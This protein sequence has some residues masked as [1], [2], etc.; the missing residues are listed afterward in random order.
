MLT[1]H[2]QI[3]VN[4]M[5][6]VTATRNS[7]HRTA[8]D[9]GMRCAYC[10]EYESYRSSTSG[11]PAHYDAARHLSTCESLPKDQRDQLSTF[12]EEEFL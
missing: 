9:T 1:R 10:E 5:N 3:V 7:S 2:D 4:N 6:R 8:G 12:E 11:V